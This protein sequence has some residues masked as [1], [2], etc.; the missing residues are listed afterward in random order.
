MHQNLSLQ[1]RSI[2]F[3][4]YFKFFYNYI[5]KLIVLFVLISI[6]TAQSCINCPSQCA[7][8]GRCIACLNGFSLDNTGAC[9]RYTPIE[10][11]K[12]YDIQT[13]GCAECLPGSILQFGICQELIQNCN[14]TLTNNTEICSQCNNSFV[15]VDDIKCYSANTANC[16]AGSLPRV[17]ESTGQAFCQKFELQRCSIP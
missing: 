6:V 1:S 8:N 2:L 13:A 12:T 17:L 14:F 5:M 4:T 7:P 10:D 11:C 15:L 3:L 9:G 16:P